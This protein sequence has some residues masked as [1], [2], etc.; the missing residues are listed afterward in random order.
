MSDFSPEWLRLREPA[1]HRSRN[2]LLVDEVAR[3]FDGQSSIQVADLGSGLGSNLRALSSHL[4]PDQTWRLLD[5][6]ARL[7]AATRQELCAW[8]GSDDGDEILVQRDG[9]RL[10]VRTEKLDLV[11]QPERIFD[12]A[13]DLVT[14]AALFDLVSPQWIDTLA[15]L[16]VAHNAVFYTVLTYDGL[17]HGLP[18]HPLN[19]AIL[20][21]L[22]VHQH[23]D[24]GFGPAAG[25]DAINVLQKAFIARGY[26]VRVAP[27]PWTLTDADTAMLT[28][29]GE[30]VV[31]AVAETGLMS[32]AD[33][34]TW[35]HFHMPD[36][37]WRAVTWTVGHADLLAVPPRRR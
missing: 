23:S 21:A 20:S 7:L 6:D 5:H 33:I 28:M 19:A 22:H 14:A 30:G 8:G 9:H 35:R 2:K 25:P 37:V 27:S 32:E 11:H 10:T 1:D 15:D 13:P 4:R 17:D 16:V 29:L 34:E 12:S 18:S 36:G 3:L 31:A 24:K 26:Q